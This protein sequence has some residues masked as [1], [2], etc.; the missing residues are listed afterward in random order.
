MRIEELA[1]KNFRNLKEQ[2]FQFTEPVT[3]IVGLNGQGKTSLLE[4]IFFLAHAKSFRTSHQSELI[5]WRLPDEP[6]VAATVQ[7]TVTSSAGSTGIACEIGP[8]SKRALINGKAVEQASLFYGQLVVVVFT[9]EELQLVKGAA[10]I[11]R[12]FIDRLLVMSDTMYV[13]T[14]VQYQRALKQRNALLTSMRSDHL[15]AHKGLAAGS[16][17]SWNML[18][19]KH[20]AVLA[21]CRGKFLQALQPLAQKYYSELTGKSAGSERIEL[22]YVSHLADG[23]TIFTEAQALELLENAAEN[24]I[25]RGTTS[26]GPHRDDIDL[27]LDVGSGF[28]PA[29]YTASQGQARS[30][31]LALVLAAVEHLAK[32]LGEPPIV[33]L[34]DVESEFDSMRRHALHTIL[35]G[36]ES[37]VIVTATE[38]SEELI[39][40]SKQVQILTL[41]AGAAVR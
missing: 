3:V 34:D 31:A 5:R 17:R 6:V 29:R 19:A 21:A 20:G 36:L 28:H 30:F 12:K 22:G 40:G 8:R 37:Q 10:A 25:R 1:V 14:A 41:Q 16:L 11:R 35:S 2:R 38:P 26:I 9:P 39:R 13:A 15:N 24:D 18:L 27:R 32:L 23:E 7:G 4:A 33:L